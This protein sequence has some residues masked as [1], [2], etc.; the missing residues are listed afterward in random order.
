VSG[1][2]VGFQRVVQRAVLHI[3]NSGRY[4]TTSADVVVALF[5]EPE[6]PSVDFLKR[7]GMTRLD[8]VNFI[9]HGLGKPLGG[10]QS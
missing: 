3:Q 4:Q 2:S 8:A 10:G 5:S 6:C 1:L 7:R 9:V